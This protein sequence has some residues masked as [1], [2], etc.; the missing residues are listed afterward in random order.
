[1]EAPSEVLWKDEQHPSI[2]KN[3]KCLKKKK[4]LIKQKS[5]AFLG[6]KK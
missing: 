1:M 2:L 4:K 3:V 5:P 6:I